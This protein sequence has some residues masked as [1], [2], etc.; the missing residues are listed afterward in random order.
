M[1]LGTGLVVVGLLY[2]VLLAVVMLAA[3]AVIRRAVR[4]GVRDALGVD[5]REVV[6]RFGVGEHTV[7][8]PHR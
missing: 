4:D 5:D 2:V 6:G 7:R 3:Y 1:F 8:G